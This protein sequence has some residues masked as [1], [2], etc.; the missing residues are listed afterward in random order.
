MCPFEE[1][2]ILGQHIS[3][4]W[5][6]METITTQKGETRKKL[7]LMYKST[8]S[9]EFIQYLKPKIEFFVKH[10]FVATW[11]DSQF[12]QCLSTF[13]NDTIV[14][15]ID[16]AKD[17]SF[18]IQNEVQSMH[19]HTYKIT[20]LVQIMWHRHSSSTYAHDGSKFFYEV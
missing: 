2:G 13:D 20:I 15:V 8:T 14:S 11:Q 6:G 12:K 17:Y 1:D 18:E 19:W 4:K 10:N 9:S 5:F 7:A 3:W 16:F